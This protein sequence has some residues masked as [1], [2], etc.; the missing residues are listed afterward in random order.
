MALHQE[1]K[2]LLNKGYGLAAET[3]RRRHLVPKSLAVGILAGLVGVGLRVGTGEMLDQRLKIAGLGPWGW[4]AAGLGGF[5]LGAF[6]VWVIQRFCKEA[7]GGGITHLQEVVEGDTSMRWL[8]LIVTKTLSLFG[9][10]AAGMGGGPEAP[11]IH[12]GGAVGK[13]VAETLHVKPGE[14]EHKALMAAGA[15]AGLS[16]AFS[17][18]LSGLVFAL[19][20]LQGNFDSKLLVA[21]LLASASADIVGRAFVGPDPVFGELHAIGVPDWHAIPFAIALGLIAGVIGVIH[22]RWVVKAAHHGATMRLRTRVLIGGAVGLVSGVASIWIPG[23]AGGGINLTPISLTESPTIMLAGG[24]F[25]A[26][27]VSTILF[28]ATSA[29]GGLMIPLLGMG[30]LAGRMMHDATAMWIP[31]WV[32]EPGVLIV[33]GMGAFFSA[34][35]RAPLTGL[36]LMLELTGNYGFMLPSLVA[37]LSAHLL[38]EEFGDLPM[39]HALRKKH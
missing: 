35:I 33:I 4:F 1:A 36:V 39:Y 32:P 34:S 13:G 11:A 20:E 9:A 6:A 15:A 22:N 18:P 26:R 8:R 19:E 27:F 30:A 37:C 17:A 14:G 5:A 10:T 25:L 29:A 7:G 31:G 21:A 28:N 3:V 12:I 38:A 23:V 2:Q 16:A 24:L